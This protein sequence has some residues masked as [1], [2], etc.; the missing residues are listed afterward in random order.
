MRARKVDE[1]YGV[2][3]GKLSMVNVVLGMVRQIKGHNVG[4]QNIVTMNA[5]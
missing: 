5:I 1:L 3:M 4:E 2:C